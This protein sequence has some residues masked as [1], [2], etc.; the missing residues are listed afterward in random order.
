MISWMELRR[1]IV[2]PSLALTFGILAV[3]TASILI[4]KAQESA[5]SLVI[6]AGR[7]SIATL[8]LAPVVI[9]RQRSELSRLTRSDFS[10]GLLSGFFLAIHFATWISSLEYTTVASSVVLVSTV[11]LWVALLAPITIK[12]PITKVV[13][14]GL[15]LALVGGA[16]VGLSDTCSLR[17]NGVYCP[18]LGDFLRGKAF[19]GDSLAVLGAFAAAGYL[20]IGRSLRSRISMTS[21]V[22][23]VYGMAAIV[24]VFMMQLASQS[25]FGYSP[26]TYV[27]IGLLALI[28][29]LIGH[30]TYNWALGYLSAAYV[31]VA[32]LGEPI[33]SSVLAYVF[34]REVPTRMKFVGVILILIGIFLA[35]R[36]ERKK[37][38]SPGEL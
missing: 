13:V 20:I 26:I 12:E 37:I 3:S 9:A 14:A 6:A 33:G 4:K 31:S 19:L 38:Q 10:L 27:W 29:Q 24:L 28:P 5:P 34:L 30:S 8:L 23:I 2:S 18:D 22:F 25:P 16:I 35:S 7:L 32:L 1:P 21:Y 36:G 17:A 11:P 15:V